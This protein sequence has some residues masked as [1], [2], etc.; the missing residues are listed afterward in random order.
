MSVFNRIAG[1]EEP[2]IPV[3]PIMMDIIRVMDQ[4]ITFAG[5][6]ELYS[7]SPE[8]QA[9]IGEYMT[10]IGVMLAEESATRISLNWPQ[11]SAVRDARVSVEAVIRH[12]LLRVEQGSMNVTQFRQW[13]GLT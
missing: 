12:A 4:E 1:I 9:E 3:W 7:L 10:A 8:Q 2:K 5:L 6:A 13:L 11:A